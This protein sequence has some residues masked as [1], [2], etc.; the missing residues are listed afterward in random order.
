MKK[1]TDF[2]WDE[3]KEKVNEKKHDV[4][5]SLAQLAFLDSNRVILEYVSHSQKEKRF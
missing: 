5:F 2:Q 3:S 1:R 4:S